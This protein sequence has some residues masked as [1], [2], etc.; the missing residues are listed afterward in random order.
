MAVRQVHA[1]VKFATDAEIN[2]AVG[3]GGPVRLSPPV[4]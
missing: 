2:L 4:H 3:H 1:I